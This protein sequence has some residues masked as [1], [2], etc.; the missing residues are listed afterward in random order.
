MRPTEVLRRLRLVF[1]RDRATAELEEEMRLHRELRARS[2]QKDGASI[3]DAVISARRQ[4][5]N[6]LVIQEASRDAW[7]LGLLDD[8]GQDVRYAARRLR[9]RPGF[10]LSV[11]AVLAL[12]IGATT[13]M[14]SAV[15]AAMLR[16]LPFPRPQE[17]VALRAVQFPK[18]LSRFTIGAA[19]ASTAP[20]PHHVRLPEAAA[21]HEVFSHVAGYAAGG[22]NLGDPSHPVRVQVGVVT[23]DFFT[24]L[25]VGALRGHTFT[26]EDGI[27]DGPL[28][29]VISHGLWQGQYG[30]AR[31]PRPR[32]SS[33]RQVVYRRRR[34]AEGFQL[35]SAQRPLDPDGNAAHS[36]CL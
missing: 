11:V 14:F 3:S 25:G 7:G 35:S 9:K 34:D 20:R 24:T 29:V 30:G 13:A 16:P 23:T 27:A 26:P 4:F 2:I 5:G 17:L 8:L 19:P 36:R 15:D 31:H 10:T 28:S 32:H 22:L 6:P 1:L 21:M 33:G 12:G 18:D